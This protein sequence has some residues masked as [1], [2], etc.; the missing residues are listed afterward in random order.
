MRC[1]ALLRHRSSR[2][3]CRSCSHAHASAA[4][5][6]W[7]LSSA[8]SFLYILCLGIGLSDG[9][10]HRHRRSTMVFL[11]PEAPVQLLSVGELFPSHCPHRLTTTQLHNA[12]CQGIQSVSISS[13]VVVV[14]PC[15]VL[16]IQSYTPT[17]DRHCAHGFRLSVRF[18]RGVQPNHR[19]RALSHPATK[20]RFPLATV[21]D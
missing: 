19:S 5:R 8:T 4:D 12:E 13:D 11:Q 6:H 20:H 10:S 9:R 14:D 2:V 18:R 1:I 16:H 17:T 3:R 21:A 15:A 7:S